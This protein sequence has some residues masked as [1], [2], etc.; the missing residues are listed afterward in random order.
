VKRILASLCFLLLSQLSF[1]QDSLKIFRNELEISSGYSFGSNALTND[2]AKTYFLKG[3][4]TDAMKDQVSDK[5][6]GS[7]RFGIEL[8]Y[9]IKY[10][11]S[12]EKIFGLKNSYFQIGI[13][14]AILIDAHFNSDVFE[15]YFRGNKNYA[16]KTADLGDFEFNQLYYQQINFSI[17]HRFK[18]KN[19]LMEWSAGVSINKGQRLLNITAP[20]ATLYTD[21]S[22]EFLDLNSQLYL[23]SNDSAKT[24]LDAFNGIGA[25][26]D[27]GFKWTNYRKRTLAISVENFG[28]ID[29]ND[30]STYVSADTSFRFEGVDISELFDFKDSV[31]NTINLDSSL[32]QPYLKDRTYARTN[33]LMPAHVKLSYK[34]PVEKLHMV[35]ETGVEQWL[36]TSAYPLIYQ[37]YKHKINAHHLIGMKLSYGGY[38]GFHLGLNYE[39]QMKTWTLK[40]KSDQIDGFLL[41]NGT[42]QGAFV[43]LSKYF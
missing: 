23:H 8:N 35:I 11:H 21:P 40:L 22:G 17:F 43:S 33:S 24:D 29:W 26:V 32:V 1:G 2:L 14:N 19:N 13:K 37:T 7:N 34:I 4:I 10:K 28:F 5:L 42:A 41:K 30:R 9:A 38:S 39:F 25:S 6:S 36:F 15:L 18:E 31:Q 27:L 12:C 16:D 3:F 20:R